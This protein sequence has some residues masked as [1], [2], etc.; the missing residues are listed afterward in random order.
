MKSAYVTLIAIL[1]AVLFLLFCRRLDLLLVI[2]P[3]SVVCA[4]L[5]ARENASSQHRI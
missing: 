4:W 5:A 3:V 2:V 1:A